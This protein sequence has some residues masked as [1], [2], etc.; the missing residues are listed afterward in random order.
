MRSM[1]RAFTVTLLAAAM[2]STIGDAALARH[3]SINDGNDARGVLDMKSVIVRHSSPRAPIWSIGT[4]KRWSAARIWDRG[5]LFVYIDTMF[6][7][8]TEYYVLIRSTGRDLQALLFRD[9]A[10]GNDRLIRSLS[11]WRWNKRRVAFKLPQGAMNWGPS[12]TFYRWSV[13]TTMTS[14]VC[15]SVCLDAAPNTGS[16]MQGRR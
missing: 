2:L 14:K 12:R 9:R 13:I 1:T 15:P 7:E 6:G 10:S 11:V 3:T 8:P 5:F 16:V 4:Y